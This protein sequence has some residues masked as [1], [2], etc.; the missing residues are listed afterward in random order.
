MKKHLALPPLA[1]LTLFGAWSH[2]AEPST[3]V[4]CSEKFI[5]HGVLV[6]LHAVPTERTA[7]ADVSVVT[8]VDTISLGSFDVNRPPYPRRQPRRAGV[9]HRSADGDF[10]LDLRL[11]EPADGDEVA[12]EGTVRAV[13]E[14][15]GRRDVIEAE[16]FCTIYRNGR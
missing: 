10:R 14:R 7:T 8:F 2:A 9:H 11:T 3:D 12:A 4:S 1:A 5:D 6:A 15:D 16:L 13:I